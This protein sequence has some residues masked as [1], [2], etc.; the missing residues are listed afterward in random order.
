MPAVEVA[1]SGRQVVDAFFGVGI[2]PGDVP[3]NLVSSAREL[4]PFVG[5][6]YLG[7]LA[8]RPPPTR[9]VGL[10]GLVVVLPLLAGKLVGTVYGVGPWAGGRADEDGPD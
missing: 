1:G 8:T 7:Y 2:Q 5:T 4:W 9:Y 3:R 10:L 6:L